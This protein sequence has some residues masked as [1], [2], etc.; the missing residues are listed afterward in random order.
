MARPPTTC[1]IYLL[2][3][4]SFG[5]SLVIKSSASDFV[6]GPPIFQQRHRFIFVVLF[7]CRLHNIIHV[8]RYL[9]RFA[10]IAFRR[11]RQGCSRRPASNRRSLSNNMEVGAIHSQGSAATPEILSMTD[12]PVSLGEKVRNA[13]NRPS[14]YMSP[15][16]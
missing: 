8:H 2:K 13:I 6:V 16:I 11:F 5:I 9:T 14:G 10:S 3:F 1:N 4:E 7:I 12:V 15:L